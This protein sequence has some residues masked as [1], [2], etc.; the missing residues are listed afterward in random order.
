MQDGVSQL[1]NTFQA[2]MR[3][4]HAQIQLEI[5]QYDAVSN[6]AEVT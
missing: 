1:G 2:Y 4:L 5:L 6:D 3:D